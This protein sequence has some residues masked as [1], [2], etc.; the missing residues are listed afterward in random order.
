V[1]EALI[2]VRDLRAG[3]RE[4]IVG[5]VSFSVS[6]GEIVGL[7]GA[8][9]SGKS[10]VL[11]AL[12]GQVEIFGG[13]IR[14]RPGLRVAYQAQ[15]PPELAELPLR[16]REMLGLMTAPGTELPQR[17][18]SVLNLRIDR[19][20]GGQQQMLFVWSTLRHPAQL[21]LL[22]EPTNNLDPDGE[23]Q[24]AE[25]LRGLGTDRGALIISHETD[26]LERVA[27]RIVRVAA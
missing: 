12:V 9:G 24:L 14:R 13:E 19:I 2:D 11:K 7:A 16:A 6:P 4:P 26:F 1:N 25:A 10:T 15:Q 3:Y 23:N 21:L 20:S 27:D 18:Q 22:D 17:V 8:N 5:P